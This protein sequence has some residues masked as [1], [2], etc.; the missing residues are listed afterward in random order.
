M[1]EGGDLNRFYL[2][3][4][5]INYEGK[6]YGWDLDLGIVGLLGTESEMEDSIRSR[7]PGDL[8]SDYAKN[9]NDSI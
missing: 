5:D 7:T 4:P 6:C 1:D 8:H 3:I 2:V 9:V